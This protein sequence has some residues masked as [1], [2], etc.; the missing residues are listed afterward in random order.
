MLDTEPDD[1]NYYSDSDTES[2]PPNGA[3][4]IVHADPDFW[5]P[6]SVIEG[7]SLP[8]LSNSPE[9]PPSPPSPEDPPSPPSPEN[10]PSPPSPIDTNSGRQNIE[11]NLRQPI[12][13]EKYSDKYPNSHA[14]E[15]LSNIP[16]ST[17][18][19]AKYSSKIPESNTNIYAPFSNKIN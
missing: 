17:S 8:P 3:N 12:F 15:P 13:S 5:E 2:E 18:G 9:D 10:P 6:P 1:E 4:R 11:N 16:A 7:A 19:F 14:G